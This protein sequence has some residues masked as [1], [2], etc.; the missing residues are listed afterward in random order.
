M[1]SGLSFLLAARECE[2]AELERLAQT[3]ELVSML[4][5]FIHAVQRERGMSNIYIASGGK[6]ASGERGLLALQTD[7]GHRE[8]LAQFDALDTEPRRA[9]NGARLFSRIAVVL[10]GLEGLPELRERVSQ[11]EISSAEATGAYSRIVSSLLAVVFEAA[12]SAGDPEI[13]R[14]LVAMFN[15]IQGKE[16]AGQ[17]RAVG[18]GVFAS[19]RVDA[20]AR[21]QWTHLIDLQQ[22]CFQLFLDFSDPGVLAVEH[23]SHDLAI[24]ADIE[25]MRRLATSP[26]PRKEVDTAL[27]ERWYE[28]CTQRLDAMRTVEDALALNLRRVCA[29]QIEHA[30]E[31]LRDQQALLAELLR[32]PGE[33]GELPATLPSRF[34]PNLERSIVAMVQDQSK[35][36]QAV[37]NELDTVKAALNDRKVVERAKGLLMAHR[38]LTEDE[39]HRVLRTMAMNQN[40]R[41]VDVAEAILTMAE[42][43]PGRTHT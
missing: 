7:A 9:H 37:S 33:L 43:L 30:R 17:E 6:R 31:E 3:S 8:V 18:G 11:L 19:G 39:A 13:S 14:A 2:I 35:R 10:H 29:R 27:T 41:L 32:P 42:V 40:R 24:D 28:A 23:A 12:D 25:R 20:T 15:F 4:G 1:K 26:S 36:L 21:Q 16:F 38:Q 5:R 34:G 22:G